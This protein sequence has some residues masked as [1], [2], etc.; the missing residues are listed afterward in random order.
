MNFD[1]LDYYV[2]IAISVVIILSYFFNVLSKRTNIPSVILLIA[3]GIGINYGLGFI[4]LGDINE[5][6][7]EKYQ[8][9]PILGAVGLISY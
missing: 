1:N 2:V 9:L 8:I 6:V 3:A 5:N 4:G 7:I